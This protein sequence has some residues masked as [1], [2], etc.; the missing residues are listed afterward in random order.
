[1]TYRE[2]A[3]LPL[4]LIRFRCGEPCRRCGSVLVPC[5]S[6]P[7]SSER[8][9]RRAA[10]DDALKRLSGGDLPAAGCFACAKVWRHHHTG[11]RGTVC[12]THNYGPA[13]G[14]ILLHPDLGLR[15]LVSKWR[16]SGYDDCADEL[17]KACATRVA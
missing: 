5:Q 15:E 10:D 3:E 16:E 6:E 13:C 9:R 8:R 1:M 14:R 12:S 11:E 17:E 2:P 7:C 4:N